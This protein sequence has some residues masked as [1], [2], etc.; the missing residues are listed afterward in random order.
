M[1][2]AI[3]LYFDQM[4]D[5]E[6][7]FL[8]FIEESNQDL[9]TFI[10]YLDERKITESKQ[11]FKSFLYLLVCISNHFHR[12][13]NI[14]IKI[15]QILNYYKDSIQAHFKNSEIFHIFQSNK[16]IILSLIQL[17][18]FTFN[19]SIIDILV[20]QNKYKE[21]S[22]IEYFLPEI[23][24]FL[25]IFLKKEYK[26][27]VKELNDNNL[28]LFNK[29]RKLGEND[30]Y[31]CSLIRNDQV[32][33]FITYVEKTNIDPSSDIEKSIY[34]T[35]PFLMNKNS[36][37]L[38][39]YSAFFGAHDI[40]KYLLKKGVMLTSSIWLYAIHGKNSDLIHFL[41]EEK[42]KT[43]CESYQYLII[44]AIKCHHNDIASYLQTNFVHSEQIYNQYLLRKHFKYYNFDLNSYNIQD[45]IE[46]SL[47]SDLFYFFCKYD[48][49]NVVEFLLQ[50]RKMD[51][52]QQ[53]NIYK[54]L[55]DQEDIVLAISIK[56]GDIS[57][58]PEVKDEGFFRVMKTKEE[59]N[60]EYKDGTNYYIYR[61]DQEIKTAL[62]VAVQKDNFDIVKLLC[63]SKKAEFRTESKKF[64]K[65]KKNYWF[66]T[67]VE[68]RPLLFE[69]IENGCIE[70][71]RYLLA[72]K[73]V[74]IKDNLIKSEAFIDSHTTA[75][76]HI[77]NEEH[78]SPLFAAAES[79]YSEIIQLLISQE[80]VDINQ[81][82]VQ[83][84][85]RSG[86]C[87]AFSITARQIMKTPLHAAIEAGKINAVKACLEQ[88]KIDVNIPVIVNELNCWR[89]KEFSKFFN[90]KTGTIAEKIWPLYLAVKSGNIDIVVLLLNQMKIDVNMKS[91]LSPPPY[92][93]KFTRTAL[94]AAVENKKAEIIEL[95][96]EQQG[97]DINATDEN[98]KKPIE[99][100]D[101]DDIIRKLFVK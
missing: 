35:N 2:G 3:Q 18:L 69:A 72:Q 84:K 16:R 11:K 68:K 60:L 7:N 100:L 75:H 65:S 17:N 71:A 22:Y 85:F 14:Y 47:N 19:Q 50:M 95:L 49:S 37:T 29:N 80:K 79:G 93:E 101:G 83:I 26:S 1:T 58:L 23:Q 13:E 40:F 90:D 73:F 10:K 20:N 33:D 88:P 92:Y 41:E 89:E 52:N 99:Y 55:P 74:D 70:I 61:Y 81:E 91:V 21:E 53:Y 54:P 30:S 76:T 43:E 44:E 46:F 4:K 9:I 6:E 67:L 38:I 12:T 5:I 97:I 51:I 31:I 94:H 66:L 42:V 36:V 63:H 77:R 98:G 25:P 15:D 45:I 27:N 56:S 62:H 59:E 64:S 48:Y 82:S 34:E 32:V 96:L 87:V 57:K 24:S 39:E 8:N 78:K 86:G 28:D